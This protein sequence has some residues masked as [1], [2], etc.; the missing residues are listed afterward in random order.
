MSTRSL[1]FMCFIVPIFGQSV[2][3]IFP[4]FLKR[5]LVF[6]LLLFSS[7]FTHYS[8]KKAFL[9]LHAV[10]WNPAFSWIHLS[11]SPLLFAS[12]LSL[13][14][15]KASSDN[16]FAFLLFF[17]FGVSFFLFSFSFFSCLLSLEQYY[18]PPSTALQAHCL[19][20]LIPWIYSLPPLHINGGFVKSYLSGLVVFPAFF[21]LS[22][23][24][25][26]RGWKPEPQSAPRS[27][28]CIQLLHFQLQIM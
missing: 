24:F 6:P 25:S 9:S 20:V 27:C 13:A 28:F 7:S 8:L 2:P 11:L 4:M 16:H 18:R 17:F 5:A 3:L 19:Q 22:L 14:I 12:L 1:S 23:V 26:M 15:C 21:S 10:L